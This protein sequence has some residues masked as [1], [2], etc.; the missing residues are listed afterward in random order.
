MKKTRRPAE[1]QSTDPTKQSKAL[2]LFD[3]IKQIT[4]I[5]NPD[6]FKNLSDEDKKSFNHFMILKSISMNP[7]RLEDVSVLY[8]YFSIIPSEQFYTLLIQ[9]FPADRRYYP[10]VKSK[11][12]GKAS[13]QL[14]EYVMTK[15]ECGPNEAREYVDLLNRTTDG[16]TELYDIVRGFGLAPKEVDKVLETDDE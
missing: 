5:Q 8:R 15:F 13:Q 1:K 3:H 6:Y 12:K 2:G 10:W 7:S 4:Q 16:Q 9:L 14:L 11:K